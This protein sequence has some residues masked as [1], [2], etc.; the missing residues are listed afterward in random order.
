MLDFV[1]G[2]CASCCVVARPARQRASA[3]TVSGAVVCADDGSGVD[4]RRDARART[5]PACAGVARRAAS[6]HGR[7]GQRRRSHRRTGAPLPRRARDREIP[8]RRDAAGPRSARSGVSRTAS[9][10]ARPTTRTST[11]C[12]IDPN[13]DAEA[14]ARRVQRSVPTSST[15]RRPIACTRQFVPNDPFYP[16]AP[17]E[18]AADRPRARLGHSAGRPDPRSS[19]PSSTR[20]IAYINATIA[21]AT[22]VQRRPTGSVRA[23]PAG[24]AVSRAR[25]PHAAV[26]R[27]RRELPPA[28]RFVAPHDFIW[29]DNVPV[30]LDGHG[31]HV[32]GTIGQLTNNGVGTAGVAFNVKLMPVKVH[33]QRVGRHLRLAE[34]GHRRRR[35]AGHP[36][37]GGQRRARSST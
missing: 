25:R 17:V 20:G 4:R 1:F 27:R 7:C 30:D 14:V 36:L 22:R 6:R 5:T 10:A 34:C 2:L 31:T 12:S 33:R 13:E 16:A 32:S 18:P 9:M 8:R 28:T 26:R 11:S 3:A 29:D 35:G 15:R 24:D 23:A 21:R 19:S 37:C